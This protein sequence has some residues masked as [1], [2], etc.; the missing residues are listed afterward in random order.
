[1][2]NRS[3]LLT[4]LLSA[5]VLVGCGTSKHVS[6]KASS[7]PIIVLYDN[8][9]H[10]Y[11]G[12]YATI[13]AMRDELKA[14]VTPNVCVVSAGDFAQG[15]SLGAI[16]KGEY[17]IQIMNKVGY[18][19]VTLGNHE[20][21]YG[22][23]R[24]KELMS[25][26]SAE[27]VDCNLFDL[28]TGN[29]MFDPYIIKSFGNVDVAFL[30]VSTPYSFVS[31]RPSYFMDENGNYKYSLSTDTFY[32]TVQESIDN[33]RKD[34][35]DYVIAI[36][37]L[38]DDKDATEINSYEL[39][40]NT[41]GLDVILDGHAHSLVPSRI[42]TNNKGKDVVVSS[43]GSYFENIGKLTISP[44]GTI[45]TELVSTDVYVNQ[46]KK[47][48][49]QIDAVK[50]AYNELGAR[51]IAVC[52]ADLL[53]D[54]P[55]LRRAVR[56][57]EK[58]IGNFLVDAI[59]QMM[60]AEIGLMGGGSVRAS[61][62]E[63]KIT[64]NDLFQ[65]FPFGNTIATAQMTGQQILDA[66]EFSVYVLPIEYG[67]FLQVS[68]LR[69]NADITIPTPV[70]VDANMKFTHFEGDQ[71]RVS[72][73]LV[74]NSEGIYVPI[75]LKRTYKVAG[76]SF[77]LKEHGDGYEVL[78]GVPVQDSGMIDIQLLEEYI[79]DNLGGVIPS[80]YAE[81]EGRINLKK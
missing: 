1:M 64:Y 58:G 68:N 18:D 13:A 24:M 71:R 69:F 53:A 26:L 47:V 50:K 44:D 9:V 22:I 3:L 11:V 62:H 10:C 67:G 81:A 7:Q 40:E 80:K 8:D 17:I 78:K 19:F 57:K 61:L 73:V 60:D 63:G 29:R 45:S 32:Q 72:N 15:G 25:M 23:P 41:N 30:G 65:V 49:A 38:G 35:A 14:T 48:L 66:L 79:T 31:S 21:D 39:A 76:M 36:A 43:T 55:D 2:K 77:L 5:L 46:D 70:R 4:L 34:G 20:F 56:F 52:E 51:E 28:S 33:A 59:R 74:K 37:H 75:D 6:S 54:E 12:G 16:S 42:L 27:V